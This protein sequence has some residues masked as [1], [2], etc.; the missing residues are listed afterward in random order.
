MPYTQNKTNRPDAIKLY[1]E[2]HGSGPPLVLISG[3]AGDA[4]IW[5]ASLLAL[6]RHFKVVIFDNRGIKRSDAPDI[7][8][9]IDMLADDVTYLMDEL[10]IESAHVMGLSMGGCIAQSL[11][12]RYPHRVRKL[13]IAASYARMSRQAQW[14]LDAALSV[15]ET[16]A[17]AKQMYYLVLPLLLSPGFIKTPQSLLLRVFG[18]QASRQQPLY[19]F[20]RQYHAQR[21]F[22]S[23]GMLT[24][25]K[26]STLVLAGEQDALVPL[27]DTQELVAGISECRLFAFPEAGHLIN[28]EQPKLFHAQ[29][30]GFLE[31]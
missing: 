11:A 6:S 24:Q 10:D 8:Y 7:P 13:I 26:A 18:E 5:I 15:Y 4:T 16:G 28:I 25:I 14:F 3:L 29:V 31:E 21:A 30:I 12:I 2:T 9:T 19:A 23:R 27:S 17:T 1:Y 20:R 22:D